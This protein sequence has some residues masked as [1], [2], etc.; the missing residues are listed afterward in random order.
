MSESRQFV[1]GV[2]L[3]GVVA[4]FYRAIRPLAAEW[5]GVDVN[6][7]TENVSYGLP[8]WGF[9]SKAPSQYEDFHRFAVTQRDLFLKL[10]VIE[11]APATLRRLSRQEGLR[12]RIITHR[13]FVSHTHQIAVQHTT[14]WLDAQGIPY[15]DLCFM[16]DKDKVGA[17]LYIEDS[18]SNVAALVAAG[19]DVLVYENSTN[20]DR[21]ET[22]GVPRAKNWTE[23]ETSY[24]AAYSQDAFEQRAQVAI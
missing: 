23:V 21:L 14:E 13:L 4:D 16:R 1:L 7:L 3:D 24:L 17:S 19:K 20:I 12:I 2:D 18:P 22:D 10:P 9:D 6:T 15:W 5:F 8:E 11:G